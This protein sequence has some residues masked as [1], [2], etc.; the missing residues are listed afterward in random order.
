MMRRVLPHQKVDQHPPMGLTQ[1][2]QLAPYPPQKVTDPDPQMTLDLAPQNQRDLHLRREVLKDLCPQ[3]V[4]A[5]PRGLTKKD[6]PLP[7]PHLLKAPLHQIK[8]Q[9]HQTVVAPPHRM[10]PD[11]Q[12]LPDQ[13][14][15]G[16]NPHS[17]VRVDRQPGAGVVHLFAVRVVL[18]TE[19]G[20]DPQLGVGPVHQEVGQD[21]QSEVDL[22]HQEVDPDHQPE[23]DPVHHAVDL[24]HQGVDPGRPEV[25]Q[26]LPEVGRDLQPGVDPGHPE[27]DPALPEV[28]QVQEADQD[29]EVVHVQDQEV[30]LVQEAG[31][32]PEV[33]LVHHEADQHL[34]QVEVMMKERRRLQAAM[35]KMIQTKTN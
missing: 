35:M 21:H 22:V 3:P 28:D 8:D 10:D 23:V 20:L 15:V 34:Q 32:A 14:E 27:V 9:R 16:V 6:L 30:V 4:V 33:D 12:S 31:H 25:D 24:L 17:V 2:L 5:V 7:H 1:P 18:P 13:S 11:L 26:A 29:Q 19:V